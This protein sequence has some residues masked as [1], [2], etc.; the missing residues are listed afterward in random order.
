MS[1]CEPLSRPTWVLGVISR[2]AP[3]HAGVPLTDFTAFCIPWI[4]LT[5][6]VSL[7]DSRNPMPSGPR[8]LH[9]YFHLSDVAFCIFKVPFAAKV[10][11]QV[12]FQDHFGTSEATV[13]LP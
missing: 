8:L 7:L 3:F 9:Q 11:F 13:Q 5:E 4:L 1:E 12:Q 2:K 6:F 10:Q